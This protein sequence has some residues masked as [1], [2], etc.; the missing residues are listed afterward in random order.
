MNR[1]VTHREMEHHVD[2]NC[3][4]GPDPFVININSATQHNL[5]FRRALWTGHYLQLTLMCIPTG[6]EIGLE[7]HPD[8]DQFIR[9][10]AGQGVVKMGPCKENME[11]Q[12]CVSQN[13]VV[14]VPAGMWHN[15]VNTGRR[16]LKLYSIYAP[17][18]HP[19]GT[20][21]KTKAEADED[22]H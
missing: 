21:H 20:I 12:K 10:E 1:Y 6:G 5:C 14:L 18:H 4:F 9:V 19:H 22:H 16:P 7:I 2:H 13:D 8:T 3:D 11:F 17:P 15:I